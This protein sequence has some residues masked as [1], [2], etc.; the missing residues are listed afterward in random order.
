[1]TARWA[2]VRIFGRREIAAYLAPRS[3]DVHNLTYL[4]FRDRLAELLAEAP[5]LVNARH[6]HGDFTPLFALPGDEDEAIEMAT[7]LLAHGADPAIEVKG[8]TAEAAYRKDGRLEI[9]DLLREA[10]PGL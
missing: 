10:V 2:S 3:R 7:F 4:G 5:A 1:M 8:Q 6:V 9:A